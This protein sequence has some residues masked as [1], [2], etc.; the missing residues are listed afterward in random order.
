MLACS[1]SVNFKANV[2]IEHSSCGSS[3]FREKIMSYNSKCPTK[4]CKLR[5]VNKHIHSLVHLTMTVDLESQ[6]QADL[7][8]LSYEDKI[9]VS[10]LTLSRT[11]ILKKT[12]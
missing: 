11:G 8:D 1:A 9:L 4:E 3:R 5:Q 12:K 2:I 7:Y 6:G 10:I